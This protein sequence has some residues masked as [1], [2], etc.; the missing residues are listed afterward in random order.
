MQPQTTRRNPKPLPYRQ[1]LKAEPSSV[2]GC[3][4]IDCRFTADSLRNQDAITAEK[5]RNILVPTLISNP[6]I[7][8]AAGDPPKK[9]EE[10]V[11]RINTGDERLSLARMTSPRGWCEPGQRPEFA[12]FTLVLRGALQVDSEDSVQTVEAGQAI[13]TEA[14]EW[15]RYSTPGAEGAEYVAICLPA[16]SPA[17]V[18]RDE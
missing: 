8:A 17:S 14:G 1:Q 18:H 3:L 2:S 11:G 5:K 6:T 4:R 13:V 15:V 12:E 9:I 7:V 10:F 16:F